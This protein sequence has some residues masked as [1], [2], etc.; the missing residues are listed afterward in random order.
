MAV[1]TV[2]AQR[3]QCRQSMQITNKGTLNFISTEP[4]LLHEQVFLW[5]LP[6]LIVSTA[7]SDISNDIDLNTVLAL[8]CCL[9]FFSSIVLHLL[10]S[11]SHTLLSISIEINNYAVHLFPIL[12]CLIWS[13]NIISATC[14]GYWLGNWMSN[15]TICCNSGGGEF[16]SGPAPFVHIF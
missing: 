10:F 9:I 16:S 4:M 6:F 5:P 12:Q 13:W 2:G 3:R 7:H 1:Y 8:I 11:H 14:R 15:N